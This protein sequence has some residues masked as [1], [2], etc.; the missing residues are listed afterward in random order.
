[1]GAQLAIKMP[2]EK[3][4]MT[5]A[6]NWLLDPKTKS[7]S[8]KARLDHEGKVATAITHKISDVMDITLGVQVSV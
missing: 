5:I 2:E 6:A 7:T 8:I 3:T 1:M 4:E